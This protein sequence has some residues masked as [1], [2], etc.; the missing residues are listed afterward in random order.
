[1]ELARLS[2]ARHSDGENDPFGF[3]VIKSDVDI[4]YSS[5]ESTHVISETGK[6]IQRNL[7]L[8][9]AV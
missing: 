5:G 6:F 8:L 2:Q 7:R 9:I 3:E 1:M 4:C